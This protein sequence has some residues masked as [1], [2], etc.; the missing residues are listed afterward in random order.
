MAKGQILWATICLAFLAGLFFF[1]RTTEN[2]T[3]STISHNVTT[4]SGESF[5]FQTYNTQNKKSLFPDQLSKIITLE[6]DLAD[7]GNEKERLKYLENLAT[8]WENYGKFA[9]A[10]EYWA[11]ISVISNDARDWNRTGRKYFTALKS[12]EDTS[13]VNYLTEKT[14][15]SLE[16]ATEIDSETIRYKVDLAESKIELSPNAMEG[17]LILLDVEKEAPNDLRTNLLLGRMGIVS[18]QFEKAKVRLERVL[19]E[20][21]ENTEAMY[22]LAGAYNG[23]GDNKKAIEILNKTKAIIKNPE[24]RK[25]ID[26]YIKTL[27]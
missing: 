11:Q 17:V 22:Y 8:S 25:E 1:A 16:K 19:K 12:G 26:A 10:S 15:S 14:Y 6:E 4:D 18:G 13:I 27:K 23:L 7:S 21:P 9:L 2:K 5:S 20:S 3:V 24:F